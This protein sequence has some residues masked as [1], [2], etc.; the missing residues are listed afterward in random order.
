MVRT[1]LAATVIVLAGAL[2]A[3]ARDTKEDLKMLDGTWQPVSGELAGEKFPEDNL[4]TLT[5]VIKDGKYTVT[6]GKMTDKGTFTVDPS[7]KPKE[8]DIVGTEGP[9]K[10]KK[11]LTI[12]ELTD[13]TLKVCYS[14]LDGK[15][16]PKEFKTTERGKELLFIYKRQKP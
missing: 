2:S 12:Y 4:K 6:A 16:R 11:Y 13:D 15:E 5:L 9:T 14:P 7:K 1:T 10:D 3:V 8:M